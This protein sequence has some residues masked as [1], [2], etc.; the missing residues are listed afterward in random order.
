MAP[1]ES[2]TQFKA[3]SHNSSLWHINTD[4]DQKNLSKTV[5]PIWKTI[6][7]KFSSNNAHYHTI[8][9]QKRI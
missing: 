3:K 6:R 1:E 7:V 2:Q 5:A 8:E 4:Q 9:G